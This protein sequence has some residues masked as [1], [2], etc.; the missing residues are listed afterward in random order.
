MTGIWIDSQF[1]GPSD[2]ANGGYC[3]G[4]V[5]A[6]LALEP[7]AAIEVT[8]HSPPPLNQRLKVNA[9]GQAIE[10]FSDQALVASAQVAELNIDAPAP[11]RLSEAIESAK[12]YSGFQQHPFPD[13]FV[14]GT[15][16]SPGDGLC[17]YPGQL[18][19]QTQ[20]CSPWHPYPGLADTQGM[21]K[22]EFIWAALDCPS[23]F[24]A[25]IGQGKVKALLGKQCLKILQPNIPVDTDYIVSAWPM[26]QQGRKYY[27][28]SA[29]FD[30]AG[31]C[32]AL[33]RGTWIVVK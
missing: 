13:C 28:G 24:G 23:Y 9:R 33:A 15:A 2:S 30:Q 8:L 25:F 17:I 29:L 1:N 19:A 22:S 32:L 7:N 18:S 3:C 31:N 26:G 10:V 11:P 27:G 20:V 14:C 12:N 21:L 4:L 16:R 6:A 5:A